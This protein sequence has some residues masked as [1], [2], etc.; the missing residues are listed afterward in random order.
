MNLI[1]LRIDVAVHDENVLP[2]I[3]REINKSVAPAYVTACTS[4]D[5]RDLSDI[6]EAHTAIVAIE[7]RV[8]I[9]EVRD[10]HRHAPGM[11]IVADGDAH[12]G[13]A[14]AAFAESDA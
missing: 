2:A 5:S 1:D 14:G 8:F 3:V 9:V 6:G 11:Q 4:S 7:G 12:V 13:L 10:E